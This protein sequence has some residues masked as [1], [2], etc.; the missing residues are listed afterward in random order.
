MLLIAASSDL[1]EHYF[2]TPY[3]ALYFIVAADV[4]SPSKNNN[5]S[6]VIA[7]VI[8]NYAVCV[9]EQVC[10][11]VP[12]SAKEINSTPCSVPMECGSSGTTDISCKSEKFANKEW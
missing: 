1:P 5:I 11:Q 9:L 3:S 4:I 2:A 10:T 6:R 12:V 8:A 7:S